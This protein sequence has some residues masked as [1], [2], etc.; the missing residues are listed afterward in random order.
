M[1]N[2]EHNGNKINEVPDFSI[3]IEL[4][5]FQ[6]L[7]PSELETATENCD[8]VASFSLM[9]SKVEEPSDC[10]LML[11]RCVVIFPKTYKHIVKYLTQKI[12]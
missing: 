8:G 10:F 2:V 1:H 5:L 4:R 3:T 11:R 9:R 6:R 7:V 12:A